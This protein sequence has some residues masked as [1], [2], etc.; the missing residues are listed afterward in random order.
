M[1]EADL[2]L[3]YISRFALNFINFALILSNRLPFYKYSIFFMKNQLYGI[4]N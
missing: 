4:N 1:T 2:A 3:H